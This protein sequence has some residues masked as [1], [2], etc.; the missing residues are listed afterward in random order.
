MVDPMTAGLN[1]RLDVVRS[2]DF[3]VD[4][5][6]SIEPGT[7]AALLGPNGSGKSTVVDAL[8]GLVPLAA[9]RIELDGRVLA[10]A[11]AGVHT[12]AEERRL[13]VVFQDYLLFDHL[14]VLDNVAFG[15]EAAGGSRRDARAAALDWLDR[16]DL[17]SL[18][19]RRPGQLSGGE[20]Q[21][22]ALA[23]ALAIGPDAL[24]LDE[25]LAALD[26]ETRTRLRRSLAEYL[27]TYAGPRLLITHDPADAFLLADT[28][29]VLEGGRITQTGTVEEIR[30][31][32]ATAYVAALAGLNLLAG[33]NRG[34][35][36]ELDDHDHV[37][38]TAD[39][40]TEGAVLV[41][42]HPNAIALHRDQPGGSPRN[43]WRTTVATVEPLGEITRVLL[44]APV[45][46][47]VDITPGAAAA[48]DV[49][50]GADV[51]AS[52]KATEI[53]LTPADPL[54]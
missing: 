26:I 54:A 10:D 2:P 4:I 25:P 20:A 33:V 12:P 14:D 30:R 18:A 46:L 28:I 19:H 41:T 24:L 32:P 51:W 22:V 8:V 52:M 6:L 44:D 34:G 17:A 53:E 1:A 9:G 39:Q 40:H 50:P 29:H 36:V 49:R 13:G 11:R 27:N 7:T 5:E 35:T 47:S 38:Q 15:L 16:L 21:R 45:P 3:K 31:R 43:T 48:L 37:I 42:I 23:R